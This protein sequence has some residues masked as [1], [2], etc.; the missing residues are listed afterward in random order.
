[1]Y[2]G[3]TM[4]PLSGR[5]LGA[6]QKIDRLARR[7]LERLLPGCAFPSIRRIMHFEGNNGPDAIKRKSPAQDEPW[8]FFQPFDL[9]DTQLLKQI[10]AHHRQLTAALRNS[11]TVRAAFEAAWL[12]HAMVDGL[13]P[14]HHHPYEAEV[15]LL[16]GGQGI[17]TRTSLKEKIIFP[18]ETLREQARNNWRYWGPKGLFST[19][20]AFE[21]GVSTVMAPLRLTQ[22]LPTAADIERFNALGIEAWFRSAAQEVARLKLYDEFYARGWTTALSRQI[23]RELAPALVRAVSVAW[24]GALLESQKPEGRA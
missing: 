18:G 11:D 15:T 6:H 7:N 21:W 8:H 2:A 10:A 23:R 9:K 13:T 14:A 24:H 4:T 5:I 12:A 20:T 1:M 16:R 17:E 22:S 3:S 19:H